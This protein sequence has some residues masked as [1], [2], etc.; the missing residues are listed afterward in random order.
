[1]TPED[2]AEHLALQEIV[3][4]LRFSYYGKSGWQGSAWQDKA[5]LFERDRLLLRLSL[6]QSLPQIGRAHV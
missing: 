6:M 1:M 2:W 4:S 3:V 5:L